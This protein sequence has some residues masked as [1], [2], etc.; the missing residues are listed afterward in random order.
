[1][2]RPTW[3]NIAEHEAAHAVVAAHF[4]L[5]VHEVVARTPGNGYTMHD[6]A[7]DPMQQAAIIAA[8]DAYGRHRGSVSYVD[9]GCGDLA[10]FERQHGLSRLWQAER[11]ALDILDQHQAA[12][13]RLADRIER[14]RRI[15]FPR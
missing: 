5:R 14:E 7:T 9:L 6:V 8:G 3:R 13:T 12:V 2:N 4:G 10:T 1:M 15:T 11:L